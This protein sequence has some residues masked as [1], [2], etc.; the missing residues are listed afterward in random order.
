MQHTVCC[1]VVVWG[2]MVGWTGAIY[3]ATFL[4]PHAVLGAR[5]ALATKAANDTTVRRRVIQACEQAALTTIRRQSTHAVQQ[6]RLGDEGNPLSLSL[7]TDTLLT[8]TGQIRQD[9]FW[10]DFYFSCEVSVDG[11]EVLNFSYTLIS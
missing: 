3:S 6:V 5:A 4:S 9:A 1:L 8:G 2:L 10:H 11:G 7:A